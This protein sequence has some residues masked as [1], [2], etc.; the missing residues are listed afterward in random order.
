MVGEGHPPEHG[1][2]M[3]DKSTIRSESHLKAQEKWCKNEERR[4]MEEMVGHGPRDC[5][6]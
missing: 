2:W 6:A 3:V 4:T 5:N 1:R